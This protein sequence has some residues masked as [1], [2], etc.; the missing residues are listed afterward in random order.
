MRARRAS[1]SFRRRGVASV[2]ALCMLGLTAGCGA[3]W[4]DAQR[5]DV[6]ARA[7]SG[8]GGSSG[9]TSSAAGSTTSSS[10][11][12]TSGVT[13]A[14]GGGSTNAA[15]VGG[16]NAATGGADPAAAS[17]AGPSPCTAHSEAPGVT[18]STITVGNI[19]SLSGP[20][21]G[22]GASAVGATRAYVA[23]LNANGGVCGRQV[24]LKSA[25]DGTDN[26][27]FR[28]VLTQMAPTV[29]GLVGQDGGGDAG[30]ADI[31]EQQQI[32]VV[33]TAFSTQFQDVSTVFDINPPFKDTS[34]SIGKY[35]WL[36]DQGVQT[37]AL[38]YVAVDQSRDQIEL[39]E[40]P[41]MQA[42]GIQI[43]SEQP[44]P[45][46]TLN[47]DS[48]ARTVANSGADYLLFLG[49]Y[50]QNAG[51]ATSMQGTGYHLKFADYFTTYGTNFIDQ[52][53][54]AA[55][56]AISFAFALP[57]EDGGQNPEQAKFLEW[58]GQVS[59]DVA[60]DVFADE[61]WA[62]SKAFFDALTQLD[63]PITRDAL[64]QKLRTFTAYDADGFYGKIN[65]GGKDNFGCYVG[66]QVVDGAWRRLV[67][68]DGFLC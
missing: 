58:M 57:V 65:L 24:E 36:H 51:M 52:A 63:G 40:K 8:G 53:G 39:T 54:S 61:A 67:P 3:R 45:L 6:V 21:P 49:G 15:G 59:P 46:S 34:R 28:S 29:L 1:A 33:T 68:A 4:S 32:P 17:A 55:E 26:G 2:L 30:G 19:S 25:D 16:T 14:D 41:L 56:G 64:V 47:Y 7:R 10:A 37:A 5:A 31:V 18:D 9:T 27:T 20:I 42:A 48:A 43:V 38:V 23:Y 50:E 66:M 44:L 62:S 12:Q 35:R 60:L 22:L 13:G 11:G